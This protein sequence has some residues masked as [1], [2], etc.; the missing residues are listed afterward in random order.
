MMTVWR[1]EGRS[2]EMFRN[3]LHT[4]FLLND[5]HKYEQLLQETEVFKH[6]NDG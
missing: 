3:M 1:K 2:S 6:F 5:I 4:A